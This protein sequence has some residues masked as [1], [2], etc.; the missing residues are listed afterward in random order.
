MLCN[1]CTVI[2]G[3]G[4]TYEQRKDG[5]SSAKRYYECKKCHD[6]VYSKEANFHELLAK[7]SERSKNN[8][9][10]RGVSRWIRY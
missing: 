10:M 4:T 9:K 7:E 8:I 3:T 2:M 1:R 6:R 5:R